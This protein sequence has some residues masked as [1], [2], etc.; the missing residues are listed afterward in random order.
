MARDQEAVT[1]EPGAWTELTNDDVTNITFQ[2]LTGSIK[3][4]CTTGAAPSSLSDGGYQYH[5]D[6]AEYQRDGELRI[7][8]TDF[9]IAA[10]IDRVFATPIN[11]RTA[12][13]VV[14]HS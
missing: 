9:A 12:L 13:V 10:G 4:R 2:V 8:L 6:A 5:A 7:P 14:D 3:V 11:G 1:C